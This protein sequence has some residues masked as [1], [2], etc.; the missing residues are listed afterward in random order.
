M[1]G[2][3][4]ERGR[5]GHSLTLCKA[6]EITRM[7][8]TMARRMS[9][10]GTI[11]ASK[12]RSLHR[13]FDDSKGKLQRKRLKVL[14]DRATRCSSTASNAQRAGPDRRGPKEGGSFHTAAAC[15]R[16][17]AAQTSIASAHRQNIER[18]DKLSTKWHR[19]CFVQPSDISRRHGNK[20]WDKHWNN[21]MPGRQQAQ[22]KKDY[23]QND[24]LQNGR[25]GQKISY[26]Q[27]PPEDKFAWGNSST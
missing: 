6:A 13:K 20:G 25:R 11:D 23:A 9:T 22:E 27:A 3:G 24:P 8:R 5:G 16:A 1:I 21:H 14:R 7:R 26:N 10:V 15:R 19:D 4:E 12:P 17:A 2:D 18:L